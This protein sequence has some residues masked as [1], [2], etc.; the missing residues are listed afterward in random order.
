M[1]VCFDLSEFIGL[2]DSQKLQY[3]TAWGTFDRIQNINSNVS[4]LR[5]IR[6]DSNERYYVYF[7]YDEKNLFRIGQFLH[8][9]RYPNSNWNVVQQD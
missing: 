4:T 7:S 1:S 2:N 6:Q 9:Q 5:S 3:R 8:Q